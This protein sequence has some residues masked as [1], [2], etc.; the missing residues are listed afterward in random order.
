MALEQRPHGN[1]WRG[2]NFAERLGEENDASF[3]GRS[4]E[5]RIFEQYLD[6]LP[7][8]AERILHVYGTGGMGK[9]YL[10]SRFRRVAE[11]RGVPFLLA[12]LRGGPL[13]PERLCARMLQELGDLLEK[14]PT[15]ETGLSVQEQ[16]RERLNRAA[17]A[18]PLVLA[19]D[20]YEEAGSLDSWIRERFL[21][22]LHTS[23]LVVTSGRFPL[24]GPWRREPGWRRLVLPLPLKE[25][26]YEESRTYARLQGITDESGM[27][28]L[29]LR[30]LGHPLSLSL[31]VPDRE[32]S[33]SGPAAEP[34]TQEDFEALLLDWLRE[35]PGEDLR[36]LV[37]AASVPRCFH[38]EL[39]SG[40]LDREI[41]TLLFERL[42]SL[43]FVRRAAG[44][45]ELHSMVRE[46]ASRVLRTRMPAAY[47]R[48]RS[49]TADACYAAA[50]MA[51][52][53]GQEASRELSEL[54]RIAGHPVLQAHFRHS[55]DTFNY[56]ENVG[57]HNLHE[58]R[59]YIRRRQELAR[60]WRVRCATPE[61]QAVFCFTFTP[62]ES[63][64]RLAGL[65][66][67]A[68]VELDREAV[69]LLRRPGGE[70][71][72]LSALLPVH[73]GTL[74][75]LLESP[76]SRAY[77]RSLKPQELQAFDVPPCRASAAFLFTTDVENL[78]S[79]EL[80][81][82]SI[83]LQFE[84]ILGGRLLITSPPPHPYFLQSVEALG[85]RRAGTAV[86]T[87]YDGVTP[88]YTYLLDTRR[89]HQLSMLDRMMQ[90][91]PPAAVRQ[92]ADLTAPGLAAHPLL[93]PREQEVA[94]LL[95]LGRTNPEIAGKLFVSE[96]AVK[97]HVHAM[98]QK[99]GTK[100]RTQL[101]KALL[102]APRPPSGQQS[103]DSP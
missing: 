94:Q 76:L 50:R 8:R 99:L 38:Q 26:S 71:A 13:T 9:S 73:S 29:W 53:Q 102:E 83:G 90:R 84:W 42:I 22:G 52:E 97:K 103:Q 58:A 45:W 66:L 21:P 100:N 36:E 64:Y 2:A 67:E 40:L 17:A 25:L 88:A 39:L 96:A 23:L 55:R 60:S 47:E 62:E 11:Q 41:P 59:E 12:D 95:V 37:L 70:A 49:R 28:A 93:T 82:D 10:L 78:E 1:G 98:L 80:R 87:V 101:A 68:L 16:C 85:Y 34:Q 24:E 89:E 3:V 86:H 75:F 79:E 51:L 69:K 92:P 57:R 63:L 19:F 30:T 5:L 91:L 32:T 33:R 54:L 31:F 46:T 77:F 6:A 44:G 61:L 18:A 65:E 27:D 4:F 74:P 72:G 20:H 48:Y 7:Q 56:Y 15:E 35:A 43:S 14:Q 81:S